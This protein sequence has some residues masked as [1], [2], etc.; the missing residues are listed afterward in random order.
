[1]ITA[2]YLLETPLDLEQVAAMMAGEQSAGTF[3]RVPGETDALRERHGAR[4]RAIT[5]LGERAQP[6]LAS[7]YLDRIGRTGPVQPAEVVID[8]PEENV[9]TNLPTLAAVVAGNLFNLGETTG[10]KLVDIAMPADYR[11]RYGVPSH[12][13]KGTRALA[14]VADSPLFGTIIKPNIGLRPGE[15]ADLV[16]TLCQAGVDFIKDDEITANPACAPFA[17][18]VVAV[19][20]VI[21][22][23]QDRTGKHVIMAFNVTDDFDT[24]RRNADFVQ[25]QGGSCIMASLN[26]CG[27][28]GMAALRAATPLAIHGHRNGIGAMGRHPMLGF[29]FAAWQSL[30]RLAGIDH[31]H[32]HGMDGKFADATQDV[33]DAAKHCLTPLGQDDDR[34]MPV[35]SSG[36]WAGTLAS[37]YERIGRSKDFMFVAGGGILAHP[38]GPAAG[39]DSLHAAWEAVAT[40]EDFATMAARVPALAQAVEKFG[41][42]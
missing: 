21:R 5:P 23:H 2:R 3:V 24:M 36:Q 34:I 32:V 25:E 42:S 4:V 12:G 18:R 39:V 20:D 31:L 13:V 19:M 35:L 7:A 26:W 10:L 6:S 1:M 28:S 40:G 22:R 37:T 11:A 14:G 9:G 29:G 8:Y 16:D 38:G 33:A 27:L 17:E 41:R 30:F 15:I